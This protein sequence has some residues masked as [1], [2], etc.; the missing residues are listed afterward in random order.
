MQ[1]Q[2]GVGGG[3]L[4][5]PVSAHPALVLGSGAQVGE[6]GVGTWLIVVQV[7]VAGMAGAVIGAGKEAVLGIAGLELGSAAVLLAGGA[8]LSLG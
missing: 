4:R 7:C 3:Q 2:A 1:G 6:A 8:A 5:G